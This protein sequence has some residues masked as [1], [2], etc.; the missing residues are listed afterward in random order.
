MAS[1]AQIA[2]NRR[3]ALRS[4]GP[5][6]AAG[7]ARSRR[8][9]HK[10]GLYA[11]VEPPPPEDAAQIDR[12]TAEYRRRLQPADQIE[13]G[14]VR[15][16]ALTQ[17][18]LS[19]I[20]ILEAALLNSQIAKAKL[21]CQDLPL[22]V[23]RA[24]RAC[25]GALEKLSRYEASLDRNFELILETLLTRRRRRREES[26]GTNPIATPRPNHLGFRDRSRSVVRRPCRSPFRPAPGI[27][28]P[29]L[30]CPAR[31]GPE[32][33]SCFRSNRQDWDSNQPRCPPEQAVVQGS[34]NRSLTRPSRNQEGRW[35]PVLGAAC[36]SGRLLEKHPA[37][38][39][40]SECPAGLHVSGSNEE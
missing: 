2:A 27:A 1:A 32:S 40:C 12:L 31:D 21:R 24:V 30:S 13:E 25:A 14:L 3:N 16:L 4:T 8:N 35:R 37:N 38:A 22:A 23:G 28:P 15:R 11:R 18:R 10:H 9:A 17:F 34:D 36:V 20:P 26:D 19:R 33:R 5:R 29:A 39:G 7:K 6:T